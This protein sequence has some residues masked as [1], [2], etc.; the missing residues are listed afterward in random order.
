MYTIPTCRK[1]AHYAVLEINKNSTVIEIPIKTL[2][3]EA[4]Y[5]INTI[6]KMKVIST[7]DRIMHSNTCG[8]VTFILFEILRSSD[9]LGKYWILDFVTFLLSEHLY[10]I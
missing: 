4:L 3:L 6:E 5:K 8:V 7:T 10:G 2:T 1:T 9:I